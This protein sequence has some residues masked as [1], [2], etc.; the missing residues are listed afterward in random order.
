MAIDEVGWDWSFM[1]NEEE[2][3]A[4]VA[5]EEAPIEF[6]LMAKTSVDSE[7]GLLEFAD[8]TITYHTRP[9]PSVESNLNDLQNSS[10]SA[11]KNGESTG[12]LL[13]KP[14]IKFVRPA[15]TP[16]VVKTD[17]VETAKKPTVKKPSKTS[18]VRGNQRNWNNLK[19]QQLVRSQFRGSRVATVNRKF[20][21]GNIKFSTVD[22]GNKEKAEARSFKFKTMNKLVRHNLVRGLPTKCFENDHNCTACLK[23]KQH[24][25]SCK[26]KLVNSVTKP[27][28]TLHMDLFCPTFDETSGI[29]RNFITEIENLK[30]LRVK[31]IRCNNRGEFRNKEMRFLFKE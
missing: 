30:E 7:A 24:K 12:G 25:V 10:S 9:F 15:D 13:S 16:T 23:E 28:H 6:A 2:N 3:H 18:N 17:K 29:L 8:D 31:I 1:A 22:M 14:E 4:L 21:T 26:S 19:S 20:P 5:N 27:L 11:S